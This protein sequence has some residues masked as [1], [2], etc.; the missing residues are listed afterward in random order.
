MVKVLQAAPNLSPHTHTKKERKYQN[1]LVHRIEKRLSNKQNSSYETAFK[2]VIMQEMMRMQ[3][4]IDDLKNQL[5]NK[6][7]ENAQ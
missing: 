6:D 1:K 7:S 2:H 4:E 3:N 5:A